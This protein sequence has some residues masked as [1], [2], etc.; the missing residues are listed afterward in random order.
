MCRSFEAQQAALTVFACDHYVTT[1]RSFASYEVVLATV[2]SNSKPSITTRCNPE[3]LD[4]GSGVPCRRRGSTV[5]VRQRASSKA[6]QKRGFVCSRC[7]AKTQ[8]G[9][10]ASKVSAVCGV[11]VKIVLALAGSLIVLRLLSGLPSVDSLGLGTRSSELLSAKRGGEDP[12]EEE[13]GCDSQAADDRRCRPSAARQAGGTDHAGR[14]E[15]S[16]RRCQSNSACQ[17]P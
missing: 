12:D 2:C 13:C 16:E 6:P 1:C 5:R 8:K 9:A 10:Y 4:F 15:Q 17:G 14:G 7:N 3:R 11:W